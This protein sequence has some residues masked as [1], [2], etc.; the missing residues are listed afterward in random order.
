MNLENCSLT[1]IG[2][3]IIQGVAIISGVTETGPAALNA[4]PL[5]A[6]LGNYGGLTKTMALKP[7]SPARNAAV[8]SVAKVDQRSFPIVVTPDIGAY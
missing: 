2:A 4:D 5:L 8:D 1:R 3:N 6:P 7:G